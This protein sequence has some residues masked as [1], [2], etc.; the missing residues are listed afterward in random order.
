ME[1]V[2]TGSRTNEGGSPDP[3]PAGQPTGLP[4]KSKSGP[5]E[6]MVFGGDFDQ[7]CRRC[8]T[9]DEAVAQQEVILSE[10]LNRVCGYSKP[11]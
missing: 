9:W 3:P 5:F 8:S 11:G 4:P 10:V 6:R 1:K 7:T 2:T